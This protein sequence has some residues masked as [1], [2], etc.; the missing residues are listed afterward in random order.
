[1]ILFKGLLVSYLSRA[2]DFKTKKR[3][4]QNFL[5]DPNAIDTIMSTANISE[6]DTVL[7]IGPGVGF[8]TEQLVQK[9]KRVVAVEIDLDAI[10]VLTGYGFDNLEIIE[11]DILKTDIS[12]LS[13]KPLKVV[14]N[15]PYYITSPI[16]VHLLGEIDELKHPN[17]NSVDEILLMVQYEVARRIVADQNSPNKEYGTLSILCNYWCE[18]QIIQKVP[19][20][21]FYPAPKVDSAIVQLKVR[22]QPYFELNNPKLFRQIVKASFNL[23]RKT[24]KNSLNMGGFDKVIID[25]A[26]QESGIDPK[27]RGET[28]SMEEFKDLTDAIQRLK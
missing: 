4:G 17:R 23:R 26:L 8:V 9:A 7:E 14:A 10:D 20:G 25:K 27:R 28:F 21:S 19:A 18:T 3:L 1:M 24:I 22:K 11:Q 13:D 15:I 5:V 2:K 12:T 16:L 6:D